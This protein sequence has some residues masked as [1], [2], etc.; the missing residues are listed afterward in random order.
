MRG[1]PSRTAACRASTSQW[2]SA[3]G[4]C[5]PRTSKSGVVLKTSPR[6]P[7]LMMSIFIQLPELG[8]VDEMDPREKRRENQAVDAVEETLL[9]Q[10]EFHETLERFAPDVDRDLFAAGGAPFE[11]RLSLPG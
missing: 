7:N 1:L 4:C 2:I 11:P 6:A 8:P 10:V 9:A 5:F 3:S